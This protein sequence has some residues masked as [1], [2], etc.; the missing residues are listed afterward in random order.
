[1]AKQSPTV[2]LFQITVKGPRPNR[3]VRFPINLAACSA[4]AAFMESNTPNKDQNDSGGCALSDGTKLFAGFVTRDVLAATAGS[5]TTPV[6]TYA[7]LSTGGNPNL[8]F[9]TAFSAGFEGSLEDAEMY[10]AEGVTFVS[11]GNGASDVTAATAIGTKLS[12][13]GGVTCVA[14][15]GQRAEFELAEVQVP[16]VAGNVRIRAR[17]IYGVTV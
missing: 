17:K 11:S 13:L 7:E 16:S 4:G 8:P 10:E 12:F 2:P 3:T 14:Q 1:M 15:T 6:P 5:P 9:E